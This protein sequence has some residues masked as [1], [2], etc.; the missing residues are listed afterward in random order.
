MNVKPTEPVID[1]TT[2]APV[3][4]CYEEM[5]LSPVNLHL[6][7]PH[8][9]SPVLI[10]GGGGGINLCHLRDRGYEVEAIDNNRQMIDYARTVRGA[11]I[12]CNSDATI[13]HDDATFAS[14]IIATGVYNRVSLYEPFATTLM[15]EVARVAQPG[16]RI[17]AG[18]F[19]ASPDVD[20]VFRTLGLA[21]TPSGNRLF[22][23]CDTLDA[24]RARFLAET[25][26]PPATIAYVFD[27]F[28][29]LLTD[30]MGL[31]R[32]V[33]QVLAE[34][35]IDAEAFIAANLGFH[36]NDLE[37]HDEDYLTLQFVRHF[38]L[39]AKLDLPPGDV[40]ALLG[41]KP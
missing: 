39:L 16:A 23:G 4:S 38:C 11:E 35:E 26:I 15:A 13:P 27:R 9:A 21:Q 2:I 24:V 25:A 31:I 22:V 19:P 30:H 14:V 34:R 12:R 5:G 1:W 40:R 36:Y 3:W 17:V 18:F 6:I 20:F 8:L 32:Q 29:S 33:T 37:P 41:C 28:V 10:V 7:E